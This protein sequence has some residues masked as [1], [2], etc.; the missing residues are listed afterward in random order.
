MNAK[1]PKITRNYS[2]KMSH[3]DYMSLR[4]VHTD[5]LNNGFN[6]TLKGVIQSCIDIINKEGIRE[7]HFR[8][9]ER[10]SRKA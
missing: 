10:N 3:E 5:A 8:F 6:I 7:N 9:F 1:E 2:L 4:A